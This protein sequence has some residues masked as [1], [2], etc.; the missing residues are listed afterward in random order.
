M[1]IFQYQGVD[2]QGHPITG[3]MLATDEKNLEKNLRAAGC[4]LIS[5]ELAKPVVTGKRRRARSWGFLDFGRVTRRDLIDFCTLVSYQTK[6]G[7]TLVAALD[8]AGQD[9]DNP[10]FRRIIDS[11]RR[12]VENGALFNEALAKHPKVFSR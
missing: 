1:P 12:D 6:V 4:W 7:V 9:C 10:R 11:V 2:A 3:A 5:S 8:V